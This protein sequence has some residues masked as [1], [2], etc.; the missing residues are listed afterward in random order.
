VTSPV[1]SPP[2]RRPWRTIDALYLLFW[3][4]GG[5]AV[6]TAFAGEEW[7][8][9]ELFGIIATFQAAGIFVGVAFLA[10]KRS[11]WRDA[12]GARFAAPD[13]RGL[14][15]G[16]GLQLGLSIALALLLGL[17]G[18][19]SPAQEVVDEASQAVG[20]LDQLV[21]FVS[22]VVLAPLSEE[23]VFRGVLLQGLRARF[24]PRAAV[25]G[26]ATAFAL[27]HLLDPNLLLAMPVFFVLGLALGYATI[28]S[29]R[30]GRAV[31]MHAGFNLIT[32]IAVLFL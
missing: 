11:P 26:S 17:L 14:L 24:G 9:F 2:E 22:L 30:L 12:L 29:G 13:L 21:V 7:T 27:V 10:R 23:L 4:I 5:A 18:E 25:W 20:S 19:T 15:E 28:N 3:W 1:D 32:V 31:A 6:G 16:V 8:V